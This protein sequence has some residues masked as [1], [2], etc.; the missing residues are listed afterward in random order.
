LSGNRALAR[1][2]PA[3]LAAALLAG[4]LVSWTPRYWQTTVSMAGI[5]ILALLWGAAGEGLSWPVELIL[6]VP[7]GVWGLL[8]LAFHTTA[9]PV[10]TLRNSLLWVMSA[11]VFFLASQILR[12]RG[13][14]TL[15]LDV[16][17]WV[18][19][20]LAV[21]EMI[22]SFFHPVRVFGLIPAEDSVVGTMLYKNHFA[23][24]MELCAPVALWKVKEGRVMPGALCFAAMFGATITSLSRAGSAMVTAELVVFLG[25][26]IFSRSMPAKSLL[27]VV[28]VL[29]VCAAGAASVVGTGVIWR[30]FQEANAYHFRGQLTRSTLLMI[31]E[32]PWFGS[33]MGTWRSLYPRFAFFDDALLANEAHNDLAQWASD[34]GLPFLGLMTALVAMLS[35]RAL[36]SVWALGVISVFIHCYVDYALRSAALSFLWFALAGGVVGAMPFLTQGRQ[37]R[38][39]RNV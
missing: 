26:M 34:G 37:S 11:V 10:L 29:I 5:T 4:I 2:L 3:V 20:F 36:E 33:G 13:G 39:T 9:I 22:Q 8:Q 23:A 24:F 28:T 31:R 32:H 14:L 19:T 7:A 25:F 16:I 18:S 12:R 38:G 21:A 30:R 27:A 35:K 6:V 15:F 1:I 17:L